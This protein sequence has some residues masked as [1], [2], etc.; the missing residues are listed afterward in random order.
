MESNLVISSIVFEIWLKILLNLVTII[1]NKLK[2]TLM[3]FLFK[4]VCYVFK[5]ICNYTFVMTRLQFCVRNTTQTQM[6]ASTEKNNC[7]FII[8]ANKKS[9]RGY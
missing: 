3:P 1:Y 5:Y 2:Y 7:L 9:S 6:Q 8:S 4:L